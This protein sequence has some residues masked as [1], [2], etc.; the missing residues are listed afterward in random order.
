[1]QVSDTPSNP[2]SEGASPARNARPPMRRRDSGQ[3]WT[4]G[5][6]RVTECASTDV[7]Q[8]VPFLISLTRE[9]MEE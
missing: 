6:W 4:M 2:D 3:G 5:R 8:L 7:P 9:E 1:M